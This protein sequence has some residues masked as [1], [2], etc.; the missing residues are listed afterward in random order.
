[1]THWKQ[2]IGIGFGLA[3]I[4]VLWLASQDVRE[5]DVQSDIDQT[6]LILPDGPEWVTMIF[7]DDDWASDPHQVALFD[8][9]ES[10]PPLIE[11]KET[12]SFW[13][14]KPE[15]K[16]W[17]RY[18]A[19]HAH[20][21]PVLVVQD[22]DGA[23]RILLTGGEISDDPDKLVESLNREF[24]KFQLK[25]EAEIQVA[26]VAGIFFN[27]RNRRPNVCPGPDCDGDQEIEPQRR[28]PVR[29]ALGRGIDGKIK[30]EAA[31][32]TFQYVVKCL[33]VVAVIFVVCAVILSAV[34]KKE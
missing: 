26:K 4:A 2:E 17:P 8:H 12:T 21:K 33:L 22:Y 19:W 6:H 24:R 16:L 23:Q 20:Q 7:T 13:H 32:F 25:V 11:L 14:L 15:S 30:K 1:M 10:H 34:N 9:F 18:K 5:L 28:Q 31:E 27:R 3:V 29:E